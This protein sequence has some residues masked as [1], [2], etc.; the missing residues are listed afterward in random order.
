MASEFDEEIKALEA[1]RDKALAQLEQFEKAREDRR[2]A[3]LARREAEDA[4]NDSRDAPHIAKAEE[5]IGPIGTKIALVE[6][7][8]GTII[9][10]RPNHLVW[11]K[12]TRK[13][14]VSADDVEALIRTCLVYPEKARFDAI[15]EELPG[16]GSR[17]IDAV[18]DLAGLM[19]R[20]RRGK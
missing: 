4:E 20:D 1:R 3:Q 14:K 2:K 15:W 16:V 10:K 5:E 19:G 8:L 7:T 12:Y 6:T 17:L 11:K 13:E 9:V 18:S